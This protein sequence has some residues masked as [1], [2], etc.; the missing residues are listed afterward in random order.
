M[1]TLEE[2]IS[3]DIRFRVEL[4]RRADGTYGFVEFKNASNA[5]NPSWVKGSNRAS[6]FESYEI[7]LHEAQ[8]RLAWLRK[9]MDWP[10]KDSQPLQAT[11]YMPNWIKCPYCGVRFSVLDT[12]RWGGGRHLSCG[13]RIE[14]LI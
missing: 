10:A 1:N 9:E 2:I 12:D 5:E 6:R 7:A 14:N 3:A 13:Q 11:E 8:Q 4:F